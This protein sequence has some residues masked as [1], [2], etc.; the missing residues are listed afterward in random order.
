MKTK[1]REYDCPMDMAVRF[2]GGRSRTVIMRRLSFGT[3]RCGRLQRLIPKAAS[4][5][6]AGQLRDLEVLIARRC[7]WN[8]P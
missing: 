7:G 4:K 1:E 3:L 5:V 6:S 8:I 2:I